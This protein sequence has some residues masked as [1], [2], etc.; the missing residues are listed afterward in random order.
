MDRAAVSNIGRPS[1]QILTFGL[2]LFDVDFDSDLDLLAV[3][4]HIQIEIEQRQDSFQFR[5]LPHL[6]LNRGYGTFDLISP[7]VSSTLGKPIVGRGAAYADY[8]QDGDLDVLVTENAGPAHLWRNEL[9]QPG[10]AS[11]VNYLRFKLISTKGNRDAIGTEVGI[12]IGGKWHYRRVKAG[13]SYLSQSEKTITF[14]MSDSSV[15]D[16]VIINWSN[17]EQQI[18]LDLPANNELLIVQGQKPI[19]RKNDL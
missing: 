4:G 13:S 15:A 11:S 17:N 6:Y 9:I 5:Q 8:D 19:S 18:L 7:S 3:N 16:S 14:G 10:S 2:F 12:K 1:L